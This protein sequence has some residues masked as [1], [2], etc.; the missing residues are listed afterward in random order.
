MTDVKITSLPRGSNPGGDCSVQ[1]RGLEMKGYLKYC[2]RSKLSPESPFTPIHQPVYEAITLKLAETMGL[3]VPRYF[4]LK[5]DGDVHFSYDSGIPN[6]KHLDDNRDSYLISKLVHLPKESSKDMQKLLENMMK[7]KLYRDL[8]MVGDVSGKKQNFS[9]IR[10][11]EP[12]HA[13]Y[14]DLGCSFADAVGGSLQ[15]RNYIANLLRDRKGALK[16]S[17]KK[18]RRQADNYL[19]RWN[20]RTNHPLEHQQDVLNLM[21]FAESIRDMDVPLFPKKGCPKNLPVSSILSGD[22]IE[23]IVGLLKLNMMGVV[24]RYVKKGKSL[25]LLI[26]E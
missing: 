23:E 5:N 19:D 11:P 14:I 22:E 8:L 16:R 4:V 2:T 21:E 17:V 25:D 15:Q 13:L 18:T 3:H 10:I 26:Q 1:Y 12:G 7:E 6:R 20:L 24:R 9:F